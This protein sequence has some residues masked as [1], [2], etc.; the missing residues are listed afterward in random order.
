[1]TCRHFGRC[2]GCSV[3]DVPYAMQLR[4]KRERL[5]TWFPDLT[6]GQ[7]VASPREWGF[8]HKVAFAFAPQTGSADLVM[9][10][11]QAGSQRVMRIDECPVH[12]VRGNRL[13]FALRDALMRGRVPPGTLRHVLIRTSDDEREAVVMLVVTANHPSLRGPVRA[14]L[15]GPERPDGFLLN[16]HD[17]PGPYMVGPTTLRLTGRGHVRD[18]VHDAVFQIAPTAFFQ[19]NVGAARVLVSTVLASVG[20]AREVLDL[21]AGSGLFSLPLA[22]RG[23]RVVS[24]EENRQAVSDAHENLRL[25][26]LPAEA[27]RL[28]AARTEDAL[29]RLSR[30]AWDAVILDP[31]RQGCA[32]RVI[33]AVCAL[34]PSRVV[35]VSCQPE[36]LS[37]ERALFAR[38]GYA[39]T[40]VTGIDMFPHTDHLEAV[41]VLTP[42][43]TV[44]E[45]TREPRRRD[46]R[47]DPSRLD[48]RRRAPGRRR[49]T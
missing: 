4:R 2:G 11:F 36:R 25:N 22:M 35:Y 46:T 17:R 7:V 29:G 18:E 21:Y 47:P 24:V 30:R 33:E 37:D 49:S 20:A 14:F 5:Q 39:L 32:P 12:S 10:H 23:A 13:A 26:R 1:V 34:A 43:S 42:A 28:I 9:G 40:Q 6:I 19:T 38:G 8:R 15:E 27:V 45:R 48:R 31:P 16:I 41:A 44:K 3:P